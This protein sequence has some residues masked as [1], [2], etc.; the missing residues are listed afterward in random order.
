MKSFDGRFKYL[1]LWEYGRLSFQI[2]ILTTEEDIF[3][4]RPESSLLHSLQTWSCVFSPS[5]SFPFSPSWLLNLSGIF[6]PS[7]IQLYLITFWHPILTETKIQ[8]VETSSHQESVL[9]LF[10]TSLRIYLVDTAIQQFQTRSELRTPIGQPRE[11]LLPRS[12]GQT[13]SMKPCSIAGMK[14]H[15]RAKAQNLATTDTSDVVTSYF[16]DW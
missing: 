3:Q 7:H 1:H 16:P 10:Q 12:M 14:E 5:S 4:E 9:Q 6:L 13:I 2:Q 11:L 15:A 8:S